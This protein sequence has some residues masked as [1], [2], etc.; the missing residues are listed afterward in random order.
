MDIALFK[1]KVPGTNVLMTSAV[2]AVFLTNA[3]E[4]SVKV[5]RER[6]DFHRIQAYKDAKM[7]EQ[8][9]EIE[10]LSAIIQKVQRQIWRYLK[11]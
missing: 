6:E 1:Y 10:K 9:E 2:E 7:K 4:N 8:A 11:T 5:A 3:D